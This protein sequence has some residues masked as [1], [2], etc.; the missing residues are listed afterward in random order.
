M[1]ARTV[2]LGLLAPFLWGTTFTFAKPVVTHFPPL[3]M[4]LMAYVFIAALMSIKRSVVVRTPYWRVF[5]IALFAVTAQGALLFWGLRGLDATTANLLLQLQVP[6]AVILG[7]LMNGERMTPQKIAGTLIALCGVAIVIGLPE[8]K[9]PFLPTLLVLL[10][11]A[12]WALGQVLVQKFSLDSGLGI[13]KG[14][15]YA[16]VIQLS[17]AT[18]LIESGQ[19]QA[20]Q[21]ATPQQWLVLAFVVV[22]GFY[23]AYVTWFAL[24]KRAP[25]NVAAPFVLLMTPIGLATAV[26]FLG[27]RMSAAQIAGAIVLLAGLAI[28]NGVRLPRLRAA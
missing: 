1:D 12:I 2:F 11:G 20:V 24:L 17:A 4:M 9:P 27:E 23:L 16:G 19:W 25:M 26:I 28:V 3:F 15:A 13:L 6:S 10:G 7:W 21:T 22:F 18:M 14:N 8:N 5:L